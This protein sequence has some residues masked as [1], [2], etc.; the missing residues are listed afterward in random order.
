MAFTRARLAAQTEKPVMTKT[1]VAAMLAL[2]SALFVAIGDVL[3]QRAAHRI[4]DTSVGNVNLLV[5][6]LR[7]QRWRWGALLLA[8]SIVLQAAALGHGSVLLVQALLTLSL[9][10]ALPINARLSGRTVTGGEW[11]WACLLTAAVMVIVVVGNPQAGR[12]TAS[13]ETWAAVAVVMG[14]ILVACVVAG[15]IWRGALAAA[16]LVRCGASSRC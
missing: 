12:S 7:D 5:R 4:A 16:L 3:E 10:F 13:L 15:R 11:I 9:L 2:S 6:L 14:P 8:A 1:D